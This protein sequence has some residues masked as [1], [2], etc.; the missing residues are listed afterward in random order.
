MRRQFENMSQIMDQEEERQEGVSS[1]TAVMLIM[2]GCAVIV[3]A[4][5]VWEYFMALPSTEIP[6]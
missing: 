2:A 3:L 1:E 5:L 4:I 6:I